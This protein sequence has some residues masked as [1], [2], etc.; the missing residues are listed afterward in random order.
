MKE[1][2]SSLKN[3]VGK[4]KQSKIMQTQSNNYFQYYISVAVL[5]AAFE[6]LTMKFSTYR[7]RTINQCSY[8]HKILVFELKLAHEKPIKNGFQHEILGAPAF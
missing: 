7:T 3:T 8:F 1:E 6:F 2:N 5:S 4:V